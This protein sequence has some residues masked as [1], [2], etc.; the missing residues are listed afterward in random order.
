MSFSVYYFQPTCGL[1]TCSVP[2]SS[3]KLAGPTL[4]YSGYY[5]PTITLTLMSFPRSPTLLTC[6][7]CRVTHIDNHQETK[8]HE[9]Q[10]QLK[11]LFEEVVS[12]SSSSIARCVVPR[13]ALPAANY[14]WRWSREPSCC[15][16][17]Y[18]ACVYS[19]LQL[20]LSSQSR[21]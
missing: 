15:V 7:S 9:L 20:D 12:S 6:D 1:W 8:K 16:T 3:C 10:Q 18:T 13:N 14:E 4:L 11:G 19:T 2:L 17:P 5:P 21:Y